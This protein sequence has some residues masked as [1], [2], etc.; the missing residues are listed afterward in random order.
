MGQPK[1][2]TTAG[3]S[4]WFKDSS[5][6][7]PTGLTGGT[8]NTSDVIAM[9][10][11]AGVAAGL[12]VSG[13]GIPADA[14]VLSFIADTSI[15]ISAPATATAAGVALTFTND[16]APLAGIK[17]FDSL[18]E[19][20]VDEFEST[21]VDATDSDSPDGIDWFKYF[22]PD[23]I[24]P[25]AMKFTMGFDEDEI[26]SVFAKMR[27]T[28]SWKILFASGARLLVMGWLKGSTPTPV[29]KNEVEVA[30]TLRVKGKVKFKKS[31]DTSS[32]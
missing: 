12:G 5:L 8:T 4:L 17:K 24:D 19:Q 20:M 10:S 13:A 32:D 31:T 15:T 11:T 14:T 1:F 6:V 29:D 16:Y 23:K 21:R 30:T 2:I 27:K 3:T 25:G 7:M 26:E 28:L 18:P 22:E 9:A